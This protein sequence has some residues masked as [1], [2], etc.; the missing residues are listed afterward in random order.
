MPSITTILQQ[1]MPDILRHFSE[2]IAE[3]SHK[4][5]QYREQLGARQTYYFPFE[6]GTG[7]RNKCVVAIDGGRTTQKLAGGDLIVVG[8]TLA[9]SPLGRVELTKEK[10]PAEA[11][12]GIVAHTAENQ[13]VEETM[14]A[15][16]ELRI[17]E[18]A[19]ADMKI[20]DGSY[21]GNTTTALYGLTG[22][23]YTARILLDYE[24]KQADGRLLKAIEA[25]LLPKRVPDT[26][27]V[28]V[29][30]SDSS[31]EFSRQAL[32]EDTQI[33]DRIFASRFLRPSEFLNP[34]PL[35][36]SR[37]IINQLA[38]GGFDAQAKKIGKDY[39]ELFHDLVRGKEQLLRAM[40]N[41][42][43][44]EKSLLWTT[45]FKP[46]RWSEF[47]PVIRIEFAHHVSSQV[48]AV[49]RAHQLIATLDQD[50]QSG[51]FLEPMSQFN[52]DR[53][54]KD[55]S[56]ATDM[57]RSLLVSNAGSMRDAVSLLRGYR[58]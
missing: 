19:A 4:I 24:Q 36:S 9:E 32:G 14:M 52:A 15:A 13:K 26:D 25:L 20:I 47:S 40:D 6:R 5:E 16:L 35:I 2:S 46:S 42:K 34:R 58:T 41:S 3:P 31:F 37:R 57:I 27:V 44:V 55:V 56:L 8:A 10:L 45:Y 54:A 11:Y 43:E 51:N 49:D 30:K 7:L 29:V 39:A 21:L 38:K 12:A 28:A 1:Q 48:S 23:A 50:I 18:K 17:F 22:P 33:S 53:N